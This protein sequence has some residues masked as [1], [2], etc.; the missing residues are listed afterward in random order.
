MS[1]K[2]Q[3]KIVEYYA[4]LS[5]KYSELTFGLNVP[6]KKYEQAVLNNLSVSLITI[7]DVKDSI[8]WL[9]SEVKRINNQEISNNEK[10][11]KKRKP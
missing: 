9:D 11:S 5:A 7:D 8:K 4:E 1:D 2:E 6:S 3:R 10:L